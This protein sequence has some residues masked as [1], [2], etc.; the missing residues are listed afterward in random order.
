MPEPPAILYLSRADVE[1]A[2]VAMPEIIERL[3]VAFRELG[4]ERELLLRMIRREE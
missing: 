3:E 1:A 4:P 2:G